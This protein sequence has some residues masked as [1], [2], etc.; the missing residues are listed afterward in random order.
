[1]KLIK[2][3]Q[4]QF[5]KVDDDDFE[6]LSKRSWCADYQKRRKCFYAISKWFNPISQKYS[7]IR[8]H[9][10]ITNPTEGLVVDHINGDTL[11][12]RKQNLRVCTSA[13]NSLN[14]SKLS[15]KNTSG[16]PGV[17]KRKRKTSAPVFQ[18]NI[19]VDG[20]FITIGVFKTAEQAYEAYK[21][22]A[23]TYFGEFFREVV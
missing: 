13:Q 12:N 16:F 4:G 9:R 8:M 20:K 18:A 5:A 21:K 10:F 19:T 2:L 17:C 3:T 1:M 15:S 23:K 14:K 11:D 7:T 22:Y 6:K